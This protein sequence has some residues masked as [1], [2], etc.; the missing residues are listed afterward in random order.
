M[1]LLGDITSPFG[2]LECAQAAA[3]FVAFIYTCMESHPDRALFN[4]DK[5]LGCIQ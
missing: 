3:W 2:F 5:T 1:T 4:N